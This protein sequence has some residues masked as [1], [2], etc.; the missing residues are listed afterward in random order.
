MLKIYNDKIF[1]CGI[2]EAGR[3]SLAGP[4]TAAAV[5]LPK[6]YKNPHVRDSKKLNRQNRIELY[7]EIVEVCIDY[8]I[9][10]VSP[11]TIDTINI[12]ESTFLAMNTAID[13]IKNKIDFTIIDG[14]K[15][16]TKK[17]QLQ[18]INPKSHYWCLTK[19]LVVEIV[20]VK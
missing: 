3:G 4:V 19:S 17:Q 7:N 14:N 1:V 15:F 18:Q 9:A 10:D 20:R 13:Q 5:V 2:D 6:N 11:K 16:K 8:A 12:L